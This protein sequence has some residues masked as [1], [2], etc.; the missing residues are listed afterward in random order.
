MPSA[1]RG[2]GEADTIHW[3]QIRRWIPL[4][5][6]VA[7]IF[8]VS[9]IPTLS[10][11]DIGLPEGFDKIAHFGEYLVLA[12]LF[13]HGLLGGE[14]REAHVVMLVLATGL[15]IAGLDE[16]PSAIVRAAQ[17]RDPSLLTM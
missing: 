10:S 13:R 2:G 17:E 9:S 15:L 1:E 4:I 16:L 14:Q 8:G 5:G 6:W 3:T 11:D 12:V 7:L